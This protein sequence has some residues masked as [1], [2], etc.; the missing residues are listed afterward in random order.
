MN[1]TQQPPFVSLEPELG[2]RANPGAP[3]LV[4]TDGRPQSDGALVVGR[5]L[6]G[7]PA[8]MRVVTVVKPMP[9]VP[10]AQIAMTPAML[11]AL[12]TEARREVDAQMERTWSETRPYQVEDGEPSLA[13]AS[14]A[15]QCAASMIVCGLGRHRVA[16]RVFG[17]ETAL[18]LMRVADVPVFAAASGL[19]HAPRRIV[20]AL[21]FSD[22]SL[23]AARLAVEM[24]S[25]NAT[26]YLVHVA[27]RDTALYDWQ[28]WGMTYKHD[29]GTA[30]SRARD[31]LHAPKDAV[32]QQ[33]LL[34]GDAATE[35][36][37]FATSV[38]ADLIA[39]GSHGRG[40]VARMLI[41]S[42]TTRIVRC[43]TCSVLTVPRS[44]VPA[45]ARALTDIPVAIPLRQADWIMELQGFTT[46]NVRRR[47]T[48][49]VD[50]TDIDAQAQLFDYPLLGAAYDP[51]DCRVE[52]MFGDDVAGGRHLSRGIGGVTSIQL[53]TDARGKDL[54]LRVAH[55]AG[56]TLLTFTS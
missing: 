55:G 45:L 43:S 2:I 34:Q 28:S 13:I 38:N 22:T 51:V 52:L 41:G 20:V 11:D 4:A 10:E 46:R 54:A 26:V 6:A 32:V 49:E 8:A 48:L 39:T 53:L 42:V 44:A 14:H 5:L 29:A 27:P 37:A 7:D 31:V 21:D 47:A 12:H 19:T 9:L 15:H 1:A 36:L 18:R 3:V 16:D 33:V 30:L 23:R 17:D 25:T 35:L 50:D 56:L 40:F 24:A